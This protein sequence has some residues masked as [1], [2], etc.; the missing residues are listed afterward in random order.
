MIYLTLYAFRG[1]FEQLLLAS[2]CSFFLFQSFHLFK[3]FCLVPSTLLIHILCSHLSL[4]ASIMCHEELHKLCRLLQH[5]PSES[6]CTRP[7]GICKRSVHAVSEIAFGFHDRLLWA[8]ELLLWL[9]YFVVLN[10]FETIRTYLLWTQRVGETV[11]ER[12]AEAGTREHEKSRW[13]VF[14]G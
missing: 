11:H 13:R 6:D 14:G 4:V 10:A 12:R 8:R 9:R 5:F 3:L 7:R 1:V 2:L